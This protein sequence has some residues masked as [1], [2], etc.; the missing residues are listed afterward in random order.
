MLVARYATLHPLQM[1]M[2]DMEKTDAYTFLSIVTDTT[3]TLKGEDKARHTENTVWTS[4]HARLVL[5][6]RHKKFIEHQEKPQWLEEEIVLRN[7]S[8]TAEAKKAR[9][10]MNRNKAGAE[11]RRTRASRSATSTASWGT[12][13]RRK[14][15]TKRTRGTRRT[16]RC[17]KTPRATG[18]TSQLRTS[19]A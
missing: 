11:A 2:V 16:A 12:P 4:K 8:L 18:S 10:A 6:S 19:T 9:K 5:Q 17:T 15:H 1:N 7:K 14:R 3:A 13:S